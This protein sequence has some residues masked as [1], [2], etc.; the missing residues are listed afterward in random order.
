[1]VQPLT[2]W[3]SLQVGDT[4]RLREGNKLAMY[5]ITCVGKEASK[6]Q[7][8]LRRKITDGDTLSIVKADVRQN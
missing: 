3:R 5:R 6:L 7:T 1:M 8:I 2:N 4:I